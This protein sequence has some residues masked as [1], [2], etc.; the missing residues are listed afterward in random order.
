MKKCFYTMAVIALFAIGF[1]ASDDS[2]EVYIESG[3]E[4]FYKVVLTCERCGETPEWAY[5]YDN[6]H[7]S[8][9]DERGAKSGYWKG[10]FYCNRCREIV[11][12]EYMNN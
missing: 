10:K 2:G 3:G 8:I 6:R 11:I 12:N 9:I 7:G 4:K 5:Y 1:A